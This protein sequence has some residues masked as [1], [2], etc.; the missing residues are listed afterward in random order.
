M[1]ALRFLTVNDDLNRG[2]DLAH[3]IRGRTAVGSSVGKRDS[4][5]PEGATLLSTGQ[6]SAASVPR[7]LGPGDAEG[8]AG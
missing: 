6:D 5:D 4:P 8:L 2:F 1:D 3:Q 7:D